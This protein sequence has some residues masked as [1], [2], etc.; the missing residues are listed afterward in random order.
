MRFETMASTTKQHPFEGIADGQLGK[1]LFQFKA[2][3]S[4]IQ[5]L[6]LLY[7]IRKNFANVI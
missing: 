2:I 4:V 1:Y 7:R 3:H 5:N 6:T